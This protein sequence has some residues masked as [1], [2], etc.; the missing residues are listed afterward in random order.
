M[1]SG[2]LLAMVGLHVSWAQLPLAV[3]LVYLQI[4]LAP[5]PA[6]ISRL[7]RHH[8]VLIAVIAL[9]VAAGIANHAELLLAGRDGATYTNSALWLIDGTNLHPAAVSPELGG[10][11]GLTFGSPGFV[12]RPDG[13]Y[14]LQFLHAPSTFFAMVGEIAGP[15]AVLWANTLV[16]AIALLAFY[17]LSR[18]FLDP[19]SAVWSTG[20]LAVTLPFIYFSRAT[21]SETAGLAFGLGGLWLALEALE[22]MDGRM[23]L[24]AGVV[25]GATAL[26]RV[27]GWATGLAL[28][29]FGA[30]VTGSTRRHVVRQMWAGFVVPGVLGL[31]DLVVYSRPYLSILGAQFLAL[32]CAVIAVRLFGERII[33]W[34]RRSARQTSVVAALRHSWIAIASMAAYAVILRPRLET[35]RGS[36]PY[37]LE[38]LQIA[39]GLPV[40]PTR[41]YA[42]WSA[43][44]LGWYLGWPLLVLGLIAVSLLARRAAAGGAWTERLVFLWFAVPATLYLA[45]PSINPDQI[46]A[47]RRLLPVVIPGLVLGGAW[48]VQEGLSRVGRGWFRLAAGIVAATV[49]SAPVIVAAVPL[50]DEPEGAGQVAAIRRLCA[51]TEGSLVLVVDD[52]VAGDLSVRLLPPMMALCGS[53]IAG[54]TA[55][56]LAGAV[57]ALADRRT[58]MTTIRLAQTPGPDAVQITAWRSRLLGAPDGTTQWAIDLAVEPV[59]PVL[60]SAVGSGS[61]EGRTP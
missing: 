58:P 21:F 23:G 54:V 31:I 57:A 61:A 9:S 10:I 46:W 50:W 40:D 22:R 24:W 19:W 49:V 47:S 2:L 14:W 55:G 4:R 27:D 3:G 48:V 36:F 56:E 51:A 38:P 37:D 53:R 45:R 30:L 32:L 29:T 12:L 7:G 16:G 26:V 34:L 41:T 35:G 43:H 44:W 11:E 17:C 6:P 13:T 8:L 5:P 39:E 59:D 52:E 28:A 60:M 18:R 15:G 1:A 42:E 20:L 33:A 25:L